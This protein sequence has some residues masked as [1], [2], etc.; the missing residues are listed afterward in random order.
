MSE[1]Y[2]VRGFRL[3][4]EPRGPDQY[5][6]RLE[7]TN[8]SQSTAPKLLA[9]LKPDEVRSL[10]EPLQRAIKESRLPRT[11]LAPTRKRPV[12]LDE[13]AGVR[14]ALALMAVEPISRPRRRESIL[15]GVGNMSDEE[16]YYWFARTTGQ[17]GSRARRALRLL[18]AD[19]GKGQ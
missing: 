12:V 14:L 5:G 17:I 3:V 18:L 8:G 7:E 1:S 11:V 4:V 15:I 2:R 13:A 19:D 10:T 6:L 9:E 16:A